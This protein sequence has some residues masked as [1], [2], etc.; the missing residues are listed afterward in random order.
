M[1]RNLLDGLAIACILASAWVAGL[2]VKLDV[3]RFLHFDEA[4]ARH[5]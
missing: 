5:F 1:K 4:G 2:T 3:T